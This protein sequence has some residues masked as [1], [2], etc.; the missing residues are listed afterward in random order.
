MGHGLQMPPFLPWHST[1]RISKRLEHE[2]VSLSLSLSLFLF[3]LSF[4][5]LSLSLSLSLS[6]SLSI[7]LSLSLSLMGESWFYNSSQVI[8]TNMNP[9]LG[10]S[11]VCVC[12]CVCLCVCVC[13]CVCVSVRACVCV[14]VCG[15][16]VT[17]RRI[18]ILVSGWGLERKWRAQGHS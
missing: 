6:C 14:C 9:A 3:S 10:R 15:V 8:F 11:C 4:F 17:W 1:G 7:A 2:K 5:L 18:V 12:V 16:P 13:V